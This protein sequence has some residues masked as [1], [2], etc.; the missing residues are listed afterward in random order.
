MKPFMTRVLL[1]VGSLLSLFLRWLSNPEQPTLPEMRAAV[2]HLPVFACAAPPALSALLV[3]QGT[4]LPWSSG[5]QASALGS[6]S[7][8]P[9]Q[10]PLLPLHGCCALCLTCTVSPYIVSCFLAPRFPC[11]VCEI[12]GGSFCVSFHPNCWEQ[13]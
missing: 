11:L 4:V 5:Q 3:H 8:S 6:F 12:V 7:S 1:Y 9:S 2:S 13:L 10:K